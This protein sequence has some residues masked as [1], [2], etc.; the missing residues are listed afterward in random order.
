VEC[1][2]ALTLWALKIAVEVG[3]VHTP[4]AVDAEGMM[5]EASMNING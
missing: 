2:E 4:D 1:A 3:D 5:V